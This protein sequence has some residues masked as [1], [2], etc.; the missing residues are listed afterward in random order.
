MTITVCPPPGADPRWVDSVVFLWVLLSPRLKHRHVST[1]GPSHG[2]PHLQ[3]ECDPRDRLQHR[4]RLRGSVQCGVRGQCHQLPDKVL[5]Q[6]AGS[7]I[8]LIRIHCR[9][10]FA[11]GI[12][13]WNSPN[14]LLEEN[15]LVR[16]KVLHKD[17]KQTMIGSLWGW[18]LQ[19]LLRIGGF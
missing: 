7:T 8:Q 2:R 12:L 13:L 3:C 4:G 15:K 14:T 16:C 18:I 6:Y 17:D 1:A 11:R 10:S 19:A 5:L 9:D